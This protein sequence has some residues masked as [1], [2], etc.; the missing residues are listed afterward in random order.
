MPEKLRDNY[1]FEKFIDPSEIGELISSSSLII[2]RSGMNTVTEIIY[3]EKPALLIPL[4]FSQNNEQLKN[5]KFLE[6]IG[7]GVVLQQN[8]ISSKKLFQAIDLMIR[9]IDNYKINGEFKNLSFKNAAQNI[10]SVINYVTKAK[11]TKI[12]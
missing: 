2:T 5:A 12:F 9:N 8:I 6:S 1:I 3:F 11:R 4:P 10:I 7:L